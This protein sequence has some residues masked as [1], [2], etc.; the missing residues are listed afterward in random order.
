MLIYNHSLEDPVKASYINADV[1]ACFRP[2]GGVRIEDCVAITADGYE[3]LTRVPKEINEI[4]AI[5]A[6]GA[7]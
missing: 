3:N 5:M 2:V 4:E 7:H 6:S 1:L